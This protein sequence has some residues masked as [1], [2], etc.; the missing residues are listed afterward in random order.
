[1]FKFKSRDSK[2][3]KK[4]Q[5]P[6][7]QPQASPINFKEK[8]AQ[9]RK[10][11]DART[12]LIS[13]ITISLFLA[14]FI[15]VPAG[16]AGGIKIGLAAGFLVPCFLLSYNYPLQALWLFLIY[17]PFSGTVTY[18]V[19]GGN[20]LFQISKDALYF[21][22][23]LG[24]I[25]VCKRKRQPILVAKKLLPT[26]ALLLFFALLTLFLVNGLGQSLPTCSDLSET[27]KFLRDASGDFILSERGIVITTP[28]KEGIPFLKGLLGLKVLLGYV[29]LIFCAY[30]LIEDK[31]KLY[32][33]GRLLVVLA[34]ICCLLGLAQYWML[35]TGRCV[36]T[37]GLVGEELFNPQL[38]AKCLVGGALTYSPEVG[39]IR[40]PGTFV[41]PWHWAWFLV[42]NAAIS[43]AVAFSDTSRLWRI[44]GVI[45]MALVFI[46][47]IISGQRLAF[48][49]VPGIIL[50]LFILTGQLANLKRFIPLGI[51]L[52]L[53]LTIGLSFF[54][55]DFIQERLDSF[56]TRWNQ[57]PPQEFIKAQ[58][59]FAIRTQKGI[60]GRGLGTG[61]SSAR[62]FGD[63]SFIE[64]FHPKLWFE[65]GLL[66]L[67]AFMIFITHLTF[68]T[69][70]AY[71]SLRDRTLK[72]FA[73]SF[74][75]F[76]LIIGYFPYWY[77]LDTDPV[78]V[79][80][81]FFAGVLF[82]LPVIEKQEKETLKAE[83]KSENKAE[84]PLKLSQTDRS[85][86]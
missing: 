36:G 27:E 63:I 58:F 80:Y 45:S 60:L 51:G 46:N 6:K 69:F 62:V 76:I 75:V 42:A 54:S 14:I 47:A 67:A 3:S 83:E 33:L 55:P 10:A 25:A 13:L 1:M 59:A 22:A 11:K 37:R 26:L 52:A 50:V 2:K 20:A 57:A 44:A 43:F 40:L 30:Y 64:T 29:P 72:S 56:V 41:S 74:W 86:A 34:I 17:M 73:S 24:L 28:C 61:T 4:S 77:P 82:R 15:G 53:L 81:W 79:Y 31:K 48:G 8:L 68:L 85:A 65:M 21:P 7:H 71:R 49:L 18:W 70:K 5:T 32:F 35:K 19:G 23:L 38:T 78:A 12:K 39:Q 84:K 9:K 66:G 16:L